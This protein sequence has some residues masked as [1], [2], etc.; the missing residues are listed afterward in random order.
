MHAGQQLSSDTGRIEIPFS[1]VTSFLG[2]LTTHVQ[3]CS[4]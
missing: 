1:D 2:L 3:K 4:G